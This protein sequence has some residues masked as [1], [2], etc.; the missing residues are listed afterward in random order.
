MFLFKDPRTML[1]LRLGQG[2]V[3]DKRERE[4][5]YVLFFIPNSKINTTFRLA[6]EVTTG[7]GFWIELP[8]LTEDFAFL[9]GFPSVEI[10][11]SVCVRVSKRERDINFLVRNMKEIWTQENKKRSNR[12]WKKKKNKHK[13]QLK[14][15]MWCKFWCERMKRMW[16]QYKSI[17]PLVSSLSSFR[18]ASIPGK[19]IPVTM[20]TDVDVDVD[21]VVTV[22]EVEETEGVVVVAGGGME[23]TVEAEGVAGGVG[24]G[25]GVTGAFSL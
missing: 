6:S 2:F 21:D 16:S 9:I 20:G 11:K 5:E 14:F 19:G 24:G 22:V 18:A 3:V 25:V 13:S 8:K 17:P 15:E 7:F 23:V 1:R 4:R 12:K 10:T